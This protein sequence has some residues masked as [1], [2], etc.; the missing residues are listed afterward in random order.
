[1]S[2]LFCTLSKAYITYAGT[3]SNLR[4]GTFEVESKLGHTGW[5]GQQDY[6]LC[7]C[8]V[9]RKYLLPT[10]TNVQRQQNINEPAAAESAIYND[11]TVDCLWRIA[12]PS[13][14]FYVC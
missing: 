1:M 6:T 7:H 10:N 11:V 9:S 12:Q 4:Q 3:P 2:W 8:M 5:P 14:P 13:L